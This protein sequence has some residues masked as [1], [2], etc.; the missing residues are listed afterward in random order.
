MLTQF[1]HCLAVLD[2]IFEKHSVHP[3]NCFLLVKESF[4]IV[5]D[6]KERFAWHTSKG[7]LLLAALCHR[8]KNL[9]A[10]LHQLL[11]GESYCAFTSLYATYVALWNLH[12]IFI[13]FGF[14]WGHSSLFIK[15]VMTVDWLELK[16]FCFFFSQTLPNKKNSYWVLEEQFL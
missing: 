4:L 9:R 7:I 11:H 16:M 5:I 10:H 13:Y 3:R 2:I 15:P 12:R 6:I 8:K 1:I 14:W